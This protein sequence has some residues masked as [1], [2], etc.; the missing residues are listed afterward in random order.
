[1]SL[2][3]CLIR[4]GFF[5]K[6]HRETAPP[7][8]VCSFT[9]AWRTE[10]YYLQ[11]RFQINDEAGVTSAGLVKELH[12][13]LFR[14]SCRTKKW[15]IFSTPRTETALLLF[16]K[17]QKHFSSPVFFLNKFWFWMNGSL[18]SVSKLSPN[19][20]SSFLTPQL[21]TMKI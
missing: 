14:K 12:C 21:L 11:F 6:H 1:M 5:K 19:I 16:L 10:Q 18:T 7:S 4:D 8:W 20:S 15:Q 13:S 9:G 2:F 17:L 3:L